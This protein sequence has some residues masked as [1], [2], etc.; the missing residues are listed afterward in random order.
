MAD[1]LSKIDQ[2]ALEAA[3]EIEALDCR[4]PVQR[5]ARIQLIVF[6]AIVKYVTPDET[7]EQRARP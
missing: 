1:S 2:I 6:A 7:P 4:N 5:N 3:R